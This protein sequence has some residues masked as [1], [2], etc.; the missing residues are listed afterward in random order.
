[1]SM[2]HLQRINTNNPIAH[3]GKDQQINQSLQTISSRSSSH[4]MS[5]D[6][7]ASART[8]QIVR[9]ERMI[10]PTRHFSSLSSMTCR[11]EDLHR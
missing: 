9:E 1:M 2:D 6:R 4:G 3:T 5:I 10:S 8:G 11:R 7:W